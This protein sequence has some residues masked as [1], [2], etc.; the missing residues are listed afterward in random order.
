[1]EDLLRHDTS[2]GYLGVVSRILPSMSDL[3]ANLSGVT[4]QTS[5]LSPLVMALPCP[6]NWYVSQPSGLPLLLLRLPLTEPSV[7]TQYTTNKK[8]V[9]ESC[10]LLYSPHNNCIC[11]RGYL[12]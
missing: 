8:K 11:N 12:S 2:H 1:M 3:Q 9:E 7:P 5:I 10:L 6:A 4:H